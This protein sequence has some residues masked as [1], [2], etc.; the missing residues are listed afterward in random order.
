MQRVPGRLDR[1]VPVDIGRHCYCSGFVP[2]TTS[3][4]PLAPFRRLEAIVRES[5]LPGPG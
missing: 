4:E 1:P 2:P 3:A 5:V